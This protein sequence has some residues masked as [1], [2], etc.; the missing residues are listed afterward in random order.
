MP[1]NHARLVT[2]AAADNEPI[3]FKTPMRIIPRNLMS[4]VATFEERYGQRGPLKAKRLQVRFALQDEAHE[5][6][7][8]SGVIKDGLTDGPKT[9]VHAVHHRW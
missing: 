1:T 8:A 9:A 3:T 4:M 2:S 5:T 6:L 7:M